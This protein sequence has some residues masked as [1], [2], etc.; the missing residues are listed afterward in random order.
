MDTVAHCGSSLIGDYAYTVQY[1]DVATIWTCLSAQ[2]NKGQLS[3][4]Q[5]I[6]RIKTRLP[7]PLLGLDPDSGS[8][9]INCYSK[10]G[11]MITK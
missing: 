3:T 9:F 4:K 7:F 8:S 10:V 2:W 5:S 6:E 11:A 1:T